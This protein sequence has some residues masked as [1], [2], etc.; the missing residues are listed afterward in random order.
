MAAF[1]AALAAD[2]KDAQAHC[3]LGSVLKQTGDFRG[4]LRSYQTG[5][6]LG[7]ARKDW[8][9]P[10]PQWVRD[11]QRLLAL[12]DKLPAVLRGEAQ[13]ADAQE[14][15][16]LADVCFFKQHYVTAAR[17]FAEAFADD[18]RL[19]DDLWAG[20]RYRGA[21]SSARAAA[22][23]G[24]DASR[25]DEEEK[26]RLRRQAREW[27]EADLV[28]MRKVVAGGRPMDLSD[29]R[30]QLE[31]WQRDA[32]LAGVRDAEALARLGADERA[33]WQQFWRDVDELRA[34]AHE[35]K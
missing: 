35:P 10:S 23:Q 26:G 17:F 22:G 4:A 31:R 15:L 27:L 20:R 29:V 19:A 13:P 32:A 14:R 3:N 21:C 28:S 9:Y 25:L 7:S 11:C 33:S 16:G 5:H 8:K 6:E 30:G 34:E 1:R 18:A 24:Q 12:D 2:P